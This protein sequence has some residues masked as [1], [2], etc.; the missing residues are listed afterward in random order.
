MNFPKESFKPFEL[1]LAGFAL[2]EGSNPSLNYRN[3]YYT[4]T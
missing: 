1:P 2:T 4:I 3:E